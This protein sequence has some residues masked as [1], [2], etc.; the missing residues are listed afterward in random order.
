MVLHGCG[1]KPTEVTFIERERADKSCI[2]WSNFMNIK[3]LLKKSRWTAFP[4][5]LPSIGFMEC[6]GLSAYELLLRSQDHIF[7]SYLKLNHVLASGSRENVWSWT[8][9]RLLLWLGH[10]GRK[11]YYKNLTVPTPPTN[12]EHCCWSWCPQRR[13]DG[14]FEKSYLFWIYSSVHD[15]NVEQNNGWYPGW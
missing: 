12:T 11:N 7:L 13:I 9:A 6:V 4:C 15:H 8:V 10:L 1:R 2:V 3:C 14:N 5:S